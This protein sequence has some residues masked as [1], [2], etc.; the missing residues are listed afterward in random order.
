LRLLLGARKHELS[1]SHSQVDRVSFKIV[2]FVELVGSNSVVEL[3]IFVFINL[4]ST[5]IEEVG[6]TILEVI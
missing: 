6:I 1:F 4:L 2:A 3:I 5:N